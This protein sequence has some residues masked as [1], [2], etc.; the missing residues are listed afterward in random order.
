MEALNPLTTLHPAQ[1]Q[2]LSSVLQM[3]AGGQ[4]PAELQGEVPQELITKLSQLLQMSM[5]MLV[6][7]IPELAGLTKFLE[8]GELSSEETEPLLRM[9]RYVVTGDPA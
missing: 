3:M 8:G 7:M 2:R 4:P 9:M 5:P 6:P 1:N